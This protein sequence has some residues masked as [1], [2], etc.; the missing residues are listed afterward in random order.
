MGNDCFSEDNICSGKDGATQ[1]EEVRNLL[2]LSKEE[3]EEILRPTV[4]LG[5]V[6]PMKSV[7]KDH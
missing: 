6:A 3:L 4:I 1:K 5:V 7:E 2:L